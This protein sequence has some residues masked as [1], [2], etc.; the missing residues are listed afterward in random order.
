MRGTD[1]VQDQWILQDRH[2]IN[3]DRSASYIEPTRGLRTRIPVGNA[4][5]EMSAAMKLIKFKRV[6]AA[7]RPGEP[8]HSS[9]FIPV[10]FPIM[11][12]EWSL[13]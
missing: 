5:T 9:S 8:G 6:D 2:L 10:A 1:R 3:R 11:K 12:Q 13:D 7:Y 4:A